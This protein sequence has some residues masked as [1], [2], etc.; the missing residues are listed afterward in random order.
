MDNM[1]QHRNGGDPNCSDWQGFNGTT[2][3]TDDEAPGL[4]LG[5][6]PPIITE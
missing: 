1:L 2:Y 5:Y 4:L 6:D 3:L